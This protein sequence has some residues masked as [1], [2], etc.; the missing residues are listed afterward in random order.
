MEQLTKVLPE[1]DVSRWTRILGALLFLL[2][3]PPVILL[4]WHTD[5]AFGGSLHQLAL[6][7]AEL[8]ETA[9]SL[10][11]HIWAPYW[12]G[13]PTAWTIIAVFSVVQLILMKIVPGKPFYGPPTANDHIPEYRANG[14]ACYFITLALFAICSWGLGLFP[15]TIIY[16]HFPS[17]LGA[18]NLFSLGFCLILYLKGR[19][20]PS[21][22]DHGLSGNFIFDYYW[23]TEL[24]PRIAGWDVKQFTNCRF[25]LMSWP[26]ILLSFAAKQ[27]ELYGLSD[28]MIVAV[29]LQLLY[30][31]KFFF[32]E[33]G[34]L[35]SLDI[36]HDRAGFYI[37]W[38][39]LVWVPAIYTSSTLYLVHHPNHL[40]PVLSW[41]IGILGA[42]CILSN[43]AADRQRQRVR[44]S[45][46]LCRVWGRQPKVIEA[47]YQNAV[48]ETRTNIL[49]ADGWWGVSRHCHYLLEIAGA[50]FWTLPAL[51]DHGLPYF[52]VIFLT[53][54][55]AHRS[56]RDERRCSDKYGEGW[57]VYC[58]HVPYRL[59]PGLY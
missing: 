31:T 17:L 9:L 46:G 13:S 37:C 58:Q 8:R 55:L 4:V 19:F 45:Q 56:F 16:D 32:W 38:G 36:M 33:T 48:G 57:K 5:I 51:F 59:I 42:L 39:C 7:V 44:A 23:G 3:C 21:G 27:H 14:P 25:G 26:L 11:W 34:Y 35:R 12:H 28:S 22:P 10:L 52:Y 15:A 53:L 40:G 18:L 43:Y 30:V 47:T 6:S 20:R 1:L 24:Y 50:F 2:V 49:L 29:A 41:S 54:L